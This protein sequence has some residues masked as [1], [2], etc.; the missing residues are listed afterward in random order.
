MVEKRQPTGNHDHIDIDLLHESLERCD[1]ACRNADAAEI[2]AIAH[3]DESR[4]CVKDR[5][6]HVLVGFVDE[7][8]VDTFRTQPVQ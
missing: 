5:V 2:S 7:R 6:V 1:V 3:S 8:D 4:A